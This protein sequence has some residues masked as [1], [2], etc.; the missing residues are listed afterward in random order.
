VNRFEPLTR[1]QLAVL[2]GLFGPSAACAALVPFRD[3]FPNTD[4]ALVLVLVVV[5]VAALGSRI[6]GMLAALSAGVWFDFFLTRPY[7][8][9]SINARPAIETTMLL[10]VIGIGVTELAAWG[11]RQRYRAG[12]RSGYL[13]GLHAAAEVAAT[14]GSPSRLAGQVADQLSEMLALKSCHFHFG[15][16]LGNPRLQH[17]GRLTWGARSWDVDRQGLPQDHETE[18]L[19]SAGGRF[20]GRFLMTPT[21]NSRPDLTRRLVAVALADQ[22]GAAMGGY[23]PMDN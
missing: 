11:R 10:C 6:G 13:S 3:S 19:V 2:A 12:Q 22:V 1:R 7:E 21:E 14:G 9:F 4:A 5:A 8:S 15:T 17:D 23:D 18:L 20:H 16:G